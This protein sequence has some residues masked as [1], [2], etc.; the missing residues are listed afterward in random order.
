MAGILEKFA[1]P[2]FARDAA[3]KLTRFEIDFARARRGHA[4]GIVVDLGDRIPRIFRR[5]AVNRIVVENTKDLCHCCH[6]SCDGP[7]WRK[8]MPR[9]GA[10]KGQR[11]GATSL[12]VDRG[13]ALS[14]HS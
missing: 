11:Q 6:S 4:V 9:A 3:E 1:K 14:A 7:L 13:L 2:E 12:L 8:P 10:R 5:I